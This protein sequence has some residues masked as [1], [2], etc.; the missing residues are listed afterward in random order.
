MGGQRRPWLD[1]GQLALTVRALLATAAA[2]AALTLIAILAIDAPVV[3]ALTEVDPKA[4]I[5]VA[6]DRVLQILDKVTGMELPRGCLSMTAILAGAIAWW[7]RRDVGRALLIVGLT[8]AVSR[9]IGSTFL[10]PL[11]G[12]LRPSE[13]LEKG[14]LDDTF[15]QGGHA[16]P[17][18]HIGHYAALA[19]ACA[20]LWPRTR[21]PVFV[22]VGFV[23][24]MRI[25]RNAHFVSDVTG[26]LAWAALAAAGAAA[27]LRPR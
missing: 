26:A 22:V 16:F 17:S 21:V 27:M 24:T 11:F 13:A 6:G 12:R 1:H 7:W 10:K 2:A 15:F 8:H 25:A 18:G 9:A 23:A 3:R 4:S 20:I 14:L 5:L 19:F